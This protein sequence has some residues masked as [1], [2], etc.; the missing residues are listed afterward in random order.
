MHTH[1]SGFTFFN[2]FTPFASEPIS[3]K[4]MLDKSKSDGELQRQKNLV[5]VLGNGEL[6]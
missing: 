2:S 6:T 5:S 4:G 1:L 3:S